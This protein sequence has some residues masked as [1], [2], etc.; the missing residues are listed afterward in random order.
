MKIEQVAVQMFSL[1]DFCKTPADI[2]KTLKRIAK[3]GYP[4]VQASALGPI[5]EEELLALCKENGLVLCATHEP[6]DTI[7]NEPMKVVERLKKLKCRY[8]AY[9]YPK[10]ID[11]SDGRAINKFIQQLNKAG[12]VLYE[13]NLVLTYHNHH[14]E[15]RKYKG[16]PVIEHIYDRTEAKYLKGE[17]DTYW[18]QFGGGDP[19][20]WC[21]RLR[22]RLPLL[23][24]K[25]YRINEE[26]KVELCEI[27]AGVLNFPEIIKE[28]DKSGCKWFIVEQDHCAGDPFDSVAQSFEFIQ[29]NLVH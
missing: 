22:R 21:R 8:T 12:R 25:D 23:H 29:K 27:G 13:N 11:F 3:I 19:V 5:E 6:S 9:P 1:R 18:V 7:L 26:N 2:A 17:I 28:A 20:D 10:G 4:A 16:Q 14:I 24:L 15:W